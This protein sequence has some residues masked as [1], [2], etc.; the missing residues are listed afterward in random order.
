MMR[1]MGNGPALP[2]SAIVYVLLLWLG[3][4][5][6]RGKG[7]LFF[8]G[9]LGLLA[10]ALRRFA[11]GRRGTL[12][13]LY[14]AALL[15]VTPIL[16]TELL[17]RVS[18]GLLRG[19]IGNYVHG[20]YHDE[21]EGIYTLDPH[22]GHALRP[23]VRRRMYWN[24]H[25]W[26]HDANV[27][28]YRGPA[29][30][31]AAALFLGDSLVYGHGVETPDTLAPLYARL[32]ARPAANLG[33]Q[34]A[35]LLQSLHLLREKGLRL[36]PAVVFVCAHPND[37]A[38]VEYWF[39]PGELRT[40]M[41]DSPESPYAPRV[42]QELRAPDRTVYDWWLLN[43]AVPLRTARLARVLLQR[44]P[45][46]AVWSAPEAEGGEPSGRPW[47]PRPS[48]LREPFAA[49]RPEASDELRLS[50]AATR[51]AVERMKQL[52]AG[53]GARLVLLD[54]GYPHEFSAAVE[55]LAARSPSRTARPG[56]SRCGARWPARRSTWPTTAIGAP[57][58]TGSWRRSWR[59]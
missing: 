28:G 56:A 33:L 17:L 58:A 55:E 52:S 15:V 18:R 44:G 3:T 47:L 29:L 50:W 59:R 31:S 36:G 46:D 40:F 23:E 6:A 25:W 4:S 12:F 57:T 49:G 20:G 24:G 9:G 16:P 7:V 37:L 21:P 32:S 26:R 41:A 10:F 19:R 53:A 30:T 38:D 34:G 51:H 11:R 27:D 35:C 22:R 54:L 45:T 42:R 43:A 2:L 8:L 48:A 14:F 5:L 1:G 39:D 13:S